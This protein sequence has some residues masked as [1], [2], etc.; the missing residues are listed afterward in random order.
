[1]HEDREKQ[2]DRQW[3]ANQ[4]QQSASTK[5]HDILLICGDSAAAL[6]RFLEQNTSHALMFEVTTAVNKPIA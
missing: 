1:M 6:L 4:P 5:T 3:N 2:N